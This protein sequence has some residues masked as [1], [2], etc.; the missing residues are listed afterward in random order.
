MPRSSGRGIDVIEGPRLNRGL[1]DDVPG[2]D[3]N[4]GG[5]EEAVKPAAPPGEWAQGLC[6]DMF[7]GTHSPAPPRRPPRAPRAPRA[8][9]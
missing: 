6:T 8:R 3:Y 5:S 9:G 2:G 4:K 1:L 7:T